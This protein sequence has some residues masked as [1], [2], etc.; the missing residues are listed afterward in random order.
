MLKSATWVLYW[1][2]EQGYQATAQLLFERGAEV[3]APGGR[4][5]NAL[6]AASFE[7]HVKVVQLLLEKGAD[8]DAPAG[9]YGSAFHAASFRGQT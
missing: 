1:A 2:A 7:G 5:G 3:D 4:Y 9:E 8:V 6:Q